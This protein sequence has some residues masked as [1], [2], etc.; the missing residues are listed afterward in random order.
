VENKKMKIKKT[1]LLAWLACGVVLAVT[2]LNLVTYFWNAEAQGS[3]L[4]AVGAIFTALIPLVFS[5]VGALILSRQPRNPIGWLL[6]LPS[7]AILVDLFIKSQ[8]SGVTVP[9]PNPSVLLVLAAYLANALWL[10]VV[11]PVFLIVLLFPTGRPLS[12][13]WRWV[14]VYAIGMVV[15][16]FVIA[17]GAESFTLDS[18][19]YSA[20]W[21]IPNPVGVLS[22][23]EINAIFFPV[24][25]IGLAMLAVL[26]VASLVLRYRRAAAVEREQIKW[27]LYAAGL[28]VAF[29]VLLLPMG[30]E[31]GGRTDLFNLFFSLFILG[32][33]LA[34]GSAILR[35]HLYD[36]DIIIRRTVIYSILTALLALIYFS[37]VVVLQQLT[38]SITGESSDV[39]IV[40]STLV[41]AALF[42]PLRRRVQS[43]IDRRFFR[44]K[45]DATKTLATFGVTVRDEV[46]LDRLTSELLHVVNETMQ[47]AS[48]SLW[49]KDFNSKG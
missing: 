19:A 26:C 37:G 24:W 35:Y 6:M 32:F 44:R 21:S 1:S 22:Q 39:A 25:P 7:L 20:G 36:I 5:I 41:I 29:Y 23:T 12:P 28:F 46:E 45:Y 33:P 10:L 43:T 9:P 49:L 31:F 40:V 3:V 2:L 38:R 27:L 47:P 48:V 42:F 17:A 30:G 13:R 14:V 16:F 11:F 18:S 8:I 15:F 4:I 34:I